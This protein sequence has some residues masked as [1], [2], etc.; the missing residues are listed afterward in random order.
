MEKFEF[1]TFRLDEMITVNQVLFFVHA[2][3]NSIEELNPY[4]KAE[5]FKAVEHKLN[6]IK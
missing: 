2:V 5:F 1:L 3:H 4:E 6:I